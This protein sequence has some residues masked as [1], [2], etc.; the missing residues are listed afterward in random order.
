MVLDFRLS[1]C[2]ECRMFSFGLLSGVWSLTANISEHCTKYHSPMKMEQT[3]YS[4][5]LAIKT[6]HPENPK[7]NK[8]LPNG[9][10]IVHTGAN[11][12]QVGRRFGIEG[13]C[14]N[15]MGNIAPCLSCASVTYCCNTSQHG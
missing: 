14:M 7:E 8:R 3:E 10:R 6:S 15:P 11:E 13:G 5:T 2:F 4:K 9:V 12:G 1:P